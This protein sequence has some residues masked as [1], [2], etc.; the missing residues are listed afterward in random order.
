MTLLASNTMTIL[1]TLKKSL[2]KEY[3]DTKD[4]GEV[5]TI[6]GWQISRDNASRTMN[7][8]QSEFIRDLVIEGLTECNTNVIPMKAGSAIEMTEP[9]DDEETDLR[10]YQRL[11]GKLI[12]LAC[13]TRPD[14]VFVVGQLSKHNVDPRKGH[15]QAAKRV[16]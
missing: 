10:T 5:K 8:T 3:Y 11:V 14:I 9:D 15:L 13:G 4:F 6:I 1:E 7:I 16:V 12:Y 2:L